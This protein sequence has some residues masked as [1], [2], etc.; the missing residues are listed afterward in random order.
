MTEPSL[1][2]PLTFFKCLADE[3]R[4]QSILLIGFSGELCVCEIQTCLELSQPKISRHLAELRNCNLLLDQRKGKW[5]YYKLHPDLP[6]WAHSV[7]MQIIE[8]Q[9]DTI[10]SQLAKLNYELCQETSC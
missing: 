9:T 1:L 8:S 10:Q 6:S 7:L 2:E 4:L 3:T 5:V